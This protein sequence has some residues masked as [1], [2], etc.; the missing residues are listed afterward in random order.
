MNR[1]LSAGEV[2]KYMTT[3]GGTAAYIAWASI[4][5]T[6]LR[7]RAG[8]K[9]QNISVGTFPFKAF[10]SIWIYRLNFVF[11]LF[12]LLIQGYTVFKH[13]FDW[14]SFIASYITIPTFVILF[15]G[16]KWYF[17]THWYVSDL[18]GY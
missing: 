3:V 13:P 4:M 6:H 7:I 8:A 1:K 5:F 10:G 14:R 16:Y 12:L 18:P 2:F 9:K 17:T 15:V 11:D